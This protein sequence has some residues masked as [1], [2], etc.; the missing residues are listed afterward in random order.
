M[1]AAPDFVRT[2]GMRLLDRLAQLGVPLADLTA[3]S[4]AVKMGSIFVAFPGTVLDGRHFI[5]EAIARGATAVLWERAGFEWDERW[6]VPNL[7]IDNLRG[8][9]S[10]IAGHIHGNPSESLWMAGVTGTNGKTSVAQWIAGASDALGRRAA[11]LGTLGNGMVGERVEAKNTTPD[12]ILLQRSL[13]EYLRRGARAVAMEVSSHGLH[14][15][16]VAGIKF[17]A[18][19][20][21]NLTRDHLDYHRTMEEYAEAKFG[22]FGARGLRHAIINVDDEWGRTFAARLKDGP[23]EVI[24]YGV[25][26]NTPRLRGGDIK[27]SEEGVRFRVESEWGSGEVRAGVLGA[28]NVSNLLAVLGALLAQGIAFARALE[29]VGALKPV[30]GRLERLGGGALPLTVIDYAHTPDALEKAL[31]ALRPA[32]A[33]GHRLV[34]VFGCGGDRDPGKRALMARA[35]AGLADHVVV[36][37]DNPRN[38]DPHAIIEQIVAG[39]R[40]PGTDPEPGNGENQGLSHAEAIEDRQVAIFTAV[41]HARP[42]DVVLLAGKGHETYQEIAG[43]RHPFS[44]SEV[45]AAAL[46]EWDRARS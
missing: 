6:D 19:I 22:L 29:A 7:G 33:K 25:G 1:I 14:Q 13:A 32:V 20:F 9:I 17:D 21:T 27:L 26:N 35:A 34:C 11:V 31:Q 43:V 45:A 36:T 4:R 41:H 28:F 10:E 44:D 46:A 2:E 18:A 38:E 39:I 40:K 23:L 3:D 37:S 24:T 30:P 8:R 16:R 12:P 15:G 42:G 5:A